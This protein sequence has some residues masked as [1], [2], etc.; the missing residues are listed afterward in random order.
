MMKLLLV[1]PT[2]TH[3]VHVATHMREADKKEVMASHCL[4]PLQACSHSL[5]FSRE[6]YAAV[7]NGETVALFGLAPCPI[8]W[9]SSPW[10]LATDDIT[11]CIRPLTSGAK[12]IVQGWRQRYGFL[13]NHVHADNE[14]N[15]RWLR[16]LGFTIHPAAPYG[17]ARQLFHR[18]TQ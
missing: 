7:V 4:D 1:P 14:T 11:R 5:E 3:I 18:F 8:W 12:S 2:L 13:E 10:L 6:K 16:W 17:V 9:T 15:I